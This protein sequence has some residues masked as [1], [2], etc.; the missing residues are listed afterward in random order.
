MSRSELKYLEHVITSRGIPIN[1]FKIK[2]MKNWLVPTAIK[3]L[4]RFLKLTRYYPKFVK[5]YRVLN[6][7]LTKL[8]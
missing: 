4:Y 3:S 8:L 6:Q 1:P 2:A 7:P 5:N